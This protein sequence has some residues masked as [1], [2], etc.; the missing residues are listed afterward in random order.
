M[1]EEALGQNGITLPNG[2]IEP[3]IAP[4]QGPLL[5]IIYGLGYATVFFIFTLLYVHALRKQNDLE[6]SR[7]EVYDTQTSILE[8][9]MMAAIGLFSAA[10]AASLPASKAGLAGFAFFLIA[11]GRSIIGARRGEGRRKLAA[12]LTTAPAAED[13]DS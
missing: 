3:F 5:M 2:Q 11:V 1:F 12:S 7:T 13:L 9:A 10:L 8:N 4:S 6:L